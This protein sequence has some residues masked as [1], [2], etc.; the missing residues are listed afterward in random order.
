MDYS[1]NI[2]R[3]LR[4]HV[5][6]GWFLKCTPSLFA[7]YSIS[8]YLNILNA[9]S[10]KYVTKP[11]SICRH[12]GDRMILDQ[13]SGLLGQQCVLNAC[14]ISTHFNAPC[15]IVCSLEEYLAF[16]WEWMESKVSLEWKDY[17]KKRLM[18]TDL[19]RICSLPQNCWAAQNF[20]SSIM[21]FPS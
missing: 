11:D 12:Y 14:Q 8:N 6:F 1:T 18:F 4:G 3:Q 16:H 7:V 13:K 2:H 17:S 10:L 21:Y 19:L 9:L 20:H 15:H 5:K